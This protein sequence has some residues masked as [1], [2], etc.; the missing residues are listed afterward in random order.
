ME[1][2]NIVI[3]RLLHAIKLHL[4][5]VTDLLEQFKR[6]KLVLSLEKN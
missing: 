2:A 5:I 1:F 3:L 4:R 6:E